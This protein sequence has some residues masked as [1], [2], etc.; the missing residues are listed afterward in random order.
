[1]RSDRSAYPPLRDYGFLSD[2]HSVALL[3]RCGSIDWCCFGRIDTPSCF[4]RLLDWERGGHFRI[5]PENGPVQIERSYVDGSLVLETR[6]LSEAGEVR[7]RDAFAMRA[8][9]SEDKACRLLR[10]IEGLRG[11]VPICIDIAPRF[12]YGSLRPWV[13]RHGPTL[14]SAIGGETGLVIGSDASLEVTDR[15]DLRARF[16]LRSGER[17]RIAILSQP[18]YRIHPDE[19]SALEPGDVDRHLDETVDWWR[20]W[21]GRAQ[22]GGLPELEP[23]VRSA[24][25]LKGLTCAPTGAIA[26]AATT[27]LPEQLGGERN[28]DYRYSWVRDSSFALQSLVALGYENEAIGFRAF[29]ERTTAGSVEELAVVYG[30]EGQHRLPEIELSE[31]DGYRGSRPVRIGNGAYRQVQLD[32]YG[33]LL[34]TA[35]RSA[36]HGH[37]PGD[38]YWEFLVQVVD[39]ACRRWREPDHGIWEVRGEPQHYVHSKVSC[40]SA[41]HHG[42]LL[43]DA[44]G[45]EAPRD[46]WRA[47]L[48]EIRRAVE[49][50]GTD[51]ER[52]IFV[53]SFGSEEVDAALLLLPRMGFVA[54]DDERMERTVN[55]I[56]D[57]L[58]AGGLIR[59]YRAKDGLPGQEGAFVA[60]SFWLVESLAGQRRWKEARELF[61]LACRQANDLGLFAE[62]YD[63]T[64]QTMLGNFPQALSHYAHITALLALAKED[65]RNA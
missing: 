27:S 64:T 16:S 63:P 41:C 2:G 22:T 52:G 3:D 46:R 47:T 51:S 19:P 56:R 53:R 14:W 6:I 38:E 65:E 49:S 39:E 55:T 23:A 12:D 37:P 20:R 34:E 40:W 28:W 42:L 7:L 11:E 13:R 33:D 17:R 18:S 8:G 30:V 21:S 54:W 60:C 36:E 15:H 44:L 4:G 45:F 32:L 25:V 10:Q 24:I 31:L 26:A 58:D 50:Q 62:Q 61:A 29:L 1:M 5:A 9:G 57:E 59:R 43:A 35:W 48:A